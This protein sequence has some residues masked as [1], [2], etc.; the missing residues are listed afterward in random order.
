M[1]KENKGMLAGAFRQNKAPKTILEQTKSKEAAEKAKEETKE[2]IQNGI[3]TLFTSQKNKSHTRDVQLYTPNRLKQKYK[4]YDIELN[5]AEILLTYV[6]S[7]LYVTVCVLIFELKIEYAIIVYAFALVFAPIILV[8]LLKNKNEAKR[9]EEIN[10]YMQQFSSGML[11]HKNVITALSD[12]RHS[13]VGGEMRRTLDIMLNKIT[14]ARKSGES[15]QKAKKMAL[16][17]I[18]EKYSN[19]QIDM[20]HDFAL[21]IEVRGGEFEEEINML[22]KKRK[23]W[24]KRVQHFQAQMKT[25][26]LASSIL[27]AVMIIVCAVIQR[28]IPANLSIMHTDLA[29]ISEVIMIGTFFL[30]LI[31]L[32]KRMSKGW[33]KEDKLM[34]K[35]DVDLMLNYIEEFDRKKNGKTSI[36]LGIVSAVIVAL[37]FLLTR[38]MALLAVGAII[39]CALFNVHNIL[40]Y[41]FSYRV[42]SEMQKAVPRWLFDVCLLMQKNNITISITESVKTA[43]AILQRDILRFL[44]K[45]KEN[46]SSPV[47]Y[48]E[49]LQEYNVPNIRTTMRMLL[50]I[51]MGTMGE[52]RAQMQ[53]LIEHNMNLLNE[54]DASEM[55]M[56]TAATVRYNIY[57]MIPTSL[58]MAGYCG[59]LVMRIFEV[60]QNML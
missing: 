20:L 25:T 47:P 33:L 36:Q 9:F 58:V 59:G 15:I 42:K 43:P 29:Q 6:I 34:P 32:L 18:A 37:S 39:T 17:Y 13:F 5:P 46:P 45:L 55:E 40:F 53:Q 57:P 7:L 14:E 10:S 12:V 54:I 52:S 2:K 51:N 3:G 1:S 41:Y 23:K 56:Q 26:A 16:L 49:F 21:R 44:N 35:K 24:V 60:M 50:S 4:E 19:S 8:H 27:Y 22:I 38:N 31:M 30:F 28:S 11:L 48:L